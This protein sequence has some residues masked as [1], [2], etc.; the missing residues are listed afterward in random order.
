M[1]SQP[2]GRR[3]RLP[4]IMRALAIFDFAVVLATGVL[5]LFILSAFMPYGHPVPSAGA[6]YARFAGAFILVPLIVTAAIIAA[7]REMY[8]HGSEWLGTALFLV[9]LF[10]VPWLFMKMIS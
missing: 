7:A 4:P 10:G 3:R 6:V 2:R 5:G 1:I 8:L 9:P